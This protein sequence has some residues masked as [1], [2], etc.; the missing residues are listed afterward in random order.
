MMGL[1]LALAIQGAVQECPL[2]NG[3]GYVEQIRSIAPRHGLPPTVAAPDRPA[4]NLQPDDLLC[5]GDIVIN[6]KES[7]FSL[8]LRIGRTQVP[9]APGARYTVEDPWYRLPFPGFG[10]F[11][12]NIARYNANRDSLREAVPRGEVSYLRS[13][14]G[15]PCKLAVEAELTA[16]NLILSDR[17]FHL[18]WR[19]RPPQTRFTIVV[20]SGRTS[21]RFSNDRAYIALDP[22]DVCRSTCSLRVE[23]AGGAAIF[24]LRLSVVDTNALDN[25][26]AALIANE[27]PRAISLAAMGL[28]ERR[29]WQLTGA[30]ILWEQACRFPPAAAAA[31]DVY[32]LHGMAE[33][34]PSRDRAE[35]SN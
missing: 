12:R 7:G 17:P 3:V 33:L 25:E 14:W 15:P 8:L 28:L 27:D 20:T 1:A 23:D 11:A 19:C 5:G 30:S 32:K 22:R 34:C 13:G 4:R 35:G 24:S 26:S 31:L 2:A 16:D 9:L 10:R 21:R 18:S 29:Q 6:P